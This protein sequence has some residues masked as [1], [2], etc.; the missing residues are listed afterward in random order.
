M[1]QGIDRQQR[2]LK[3]ILVGFPPELLLLHNPPEL[4]PLLQ[5]EVVVI[6]AVGVLE[7]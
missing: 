6:Q 2:Q 1:I 7:Q 4:L 5:Q 3:E